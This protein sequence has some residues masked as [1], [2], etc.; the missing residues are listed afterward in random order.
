[1]ATNKPYRNPFNITSGQYVIYGGLLYKVSSVMPNDNALQIYPVKKEMQVF[2][3]LMVP[4][5]HVIPANETT[6]LLYEKN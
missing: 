5:S 2:G 3:T 6:S 1:M 4:I